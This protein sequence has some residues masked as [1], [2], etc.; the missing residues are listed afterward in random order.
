MITISF[1]KNA[2]GIYNGFTTNGHAG[3]ADSGYDIVCA[4]VSVLIINTI[5]SIEMFTSDQINL[6]GGDV[7]SKI[8]F[9]ILSEVSNETTLLLNSLILGLKSII[10]EYGQE[11]IDLKV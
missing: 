7:T 3:Y 1:T 4:S 8:E 10:E 11:Y 9:L 5:N 2:E 6:V